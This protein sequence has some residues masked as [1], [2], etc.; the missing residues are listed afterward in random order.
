MLFRSSLAPL[1]LEAQAL[2]AA[3]LAAAG[4]YAFGAGLSRR[5]GLILVMSFAGFVTWMVSRLGA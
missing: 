3:A 2:L 1:A 4:F 5:D